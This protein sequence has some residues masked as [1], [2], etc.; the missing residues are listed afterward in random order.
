MRVAT[1]DPAIAHTSWAFNRS[2]STGGGHAQH[3]GPHAHQHESEQLTAGV[4]ADLA[5][6]LK[7][8]KATKSRGPK[9]TSLN[10]SGAAPASTSRLVQRHGA[11]KRGVGERSHNEGQHRPAQPMSAVALAWRRH[12]G[13]RTGIDRAG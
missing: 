8:G 10:R 11:R 3:Q 4:S 12:P 13:D 7:R 5:E 9:R 1:A 2:H 6:G